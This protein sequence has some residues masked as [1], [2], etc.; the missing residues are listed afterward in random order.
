VRQCGE[1][2]MQTWILFDLVLIMKFMEA[3]LWSTLSWI[4]FWKNL[5]VL[6]DDLSPGG[7]TC[8]KNAW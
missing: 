2:M 1:D 6:T 8:K 7:S 4:S 3:C 5:K